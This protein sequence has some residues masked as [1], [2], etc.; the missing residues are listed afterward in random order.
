MALSEITTFQG[1]VFARPV[2]FRDFYNVNRLDPWWNHLPF[3][4][5][6]A[7]A[8]IYVIF[9]LIFAVIEVISFYLTGLEN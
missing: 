2:V 7:L 8:H 5:E 1:N 6:A 3:I 4:K 9:Y